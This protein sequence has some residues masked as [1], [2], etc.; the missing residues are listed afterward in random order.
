MPYPVELTLFIVIGVL[1]AGFFLFLFFYGPLKGFLY[2]R[3]T[4]RM[5]YKAVHRIA[6]NQDF[7]LINKWSRQ[8]YDAEAQ[9]I[10]VDHLLFGNKY[11]YVIKDR[12][13]RGVISGK[14]EDPNW[15]NYIG[16]KK[17]KVPSNPMILNKIRT[18]RLS[19]LTGLNRKYFISIVLVNDDCLVTPF[20]NQ[21]EDNLLVPMGKLEKLIEAIEA[22]KDVAPLKKEQLAIA[23]RD[24]AELNQT[25][26]KYG[27]KKN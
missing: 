15:T 1:L 20:E 9:W 6:L 18:D 27:R 10:H 16:K 13:Y 23:V 11:I 19:L 3:Y 12:Y 4:I 22:R 26:S 7:Y 2:E 24:F 17:K 14:I 25:E 8:I 21:Q 5:Y